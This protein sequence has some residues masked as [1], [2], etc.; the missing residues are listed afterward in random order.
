MKEAYIIQILWPEKNEDMYVF[1]YGVRNETN[2]TINW[3]ISNK[4]SCKIIAIFNLKF[5]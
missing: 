3:I 5:K 4:F 2:E 1:Y